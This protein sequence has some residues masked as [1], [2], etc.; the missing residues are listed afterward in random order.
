MDVSRA[1]D[2]DIP[3]DI[4][5]WHTLPHFGSPS[6]K[7]ARAVLEQVAYSEVEVDE[8]KV[9]EDAVTESESKAEQDPKA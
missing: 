4:P 6:M 9:E 7:D 2:R 3:C 8:V 1:H 5:S